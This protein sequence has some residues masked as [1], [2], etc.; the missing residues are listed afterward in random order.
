VLLRQ[1]WSMVHVA[2]HDDEPPV[3]L[4]VPQHV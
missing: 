4:I 1:I 3:A 2:W